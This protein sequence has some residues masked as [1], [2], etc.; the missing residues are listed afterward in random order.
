V[1]GRQNVWGA[2]GVLLAVGVD[3]GMRVIQPD[4]RVKANPELDVCIVILI[5]LCA[6]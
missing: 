1:A 4:A 6:A 2:D 5:R 3:R